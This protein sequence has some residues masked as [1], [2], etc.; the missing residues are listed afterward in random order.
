MAETTQVQI[1]VMAEA[2]CLY[3]GKAAVLLDYTLSNKKT[4]KI[5]SNTG[6][7]D[8]RHGL[9]IIVTYDIAFSQKRFDM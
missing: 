3:H 6:L 2:V 7:S 1:L 8:M 9:K 4:H 5:S